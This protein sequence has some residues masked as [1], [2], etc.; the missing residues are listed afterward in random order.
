MLVTDDKRV[1]GAHDWEH[2]SRLTKSNT[3]TLSEISKLKIYDKYAV[4]YDEIITQYFLEHPNVY[5]VTDKIGDIRLLLDSF[6]FYRDRLLVEVFSVDNYI[7]ALNAGIRYPMLCVGDERDLQQ[8]FRLLETGLISMITCP[9]Q[10]LETRLTDLQ[11]LH[12]R[13]VNIFAFT[14]NNV[15]FMNQYLGKTVTG[16]YTDS[17][18]PKRNF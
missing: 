4:L 12:D 8:H 9:V 3:R 14:T 10:L 6:P 15:D 11:K 16:F 5:L 7:K 13:G 18:L 17:I 2:F 1:L